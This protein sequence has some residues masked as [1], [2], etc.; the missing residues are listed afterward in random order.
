MGNA[1]KSRRSASPTLIV[2][3][4]LSVGTVQQTLTLL[5]SV[6]KY[7]LHSL[8]AICPVFSTIILIHLYRKVVSFPKKG[9]LNNTSSVFL[10]I[11]S[12][13]LSLSVLSLLIIWICEFFA[14][15]AVKS[16]LTLLSLTF[17]SVLFLEL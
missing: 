3:L 5:T 1:Q 12:I 9:G 8:A 15:I 16:P 10:P 14:L 13:A 7:P 11:W 4:G 6:L 17:I 2:A